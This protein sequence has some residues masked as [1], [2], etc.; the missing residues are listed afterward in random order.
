MNTRKTVN[1]FQL[2][3]WS[4]IIEKQC[5][6]GESVRTW[7]RKNGIAEKTYYYWL[8]KCKRHNKIEAQN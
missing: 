4:G 3:K 2:S 5:A 7:C 6:S 1:E 8:R